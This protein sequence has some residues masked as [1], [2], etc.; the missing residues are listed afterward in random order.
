MASWDEAQRLLEAAVRHDPNRI[1][2]RLAL[3]G[4]YA[5][6]GDTTRAREMYLWIASAAVV[7]P[8][9]DLYTRQAAERLKRLAGK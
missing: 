3:A 4:I 8:N 9:D 2:H 7:E 6:R 1:I 5:D